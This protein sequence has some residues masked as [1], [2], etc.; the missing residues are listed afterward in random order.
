MKKKKELKLFLP[1]IFLLFLSCTLKKQT[2]E[3]KNGDIIFQISKSNQS[4]AIQIATNSKYSHVGIIFKK[5]GKYYVYEAIRR[6]TYTPLSEWIKRGENG[7]YVV[8]RLKNAKQILTPQTLRKMKKEGKKFFGKPYDLYFEWS[9]DK[10]YCSELVWKIYK[11]SAGV[12]IG[13]LRKLKDFNLSNK[14][15]R[16]KLTER[17]GAKIPL[18][19]PV[20]SPA[21]LFNSPK[22]IT[23]YK[24]D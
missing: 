3:L 17:F 19:E 9:D 23:V 10:L 13:E 22:L 1:L 5:N 24:R 2:P 16:K 18:N 7:E 14:Y 21:D 20:I 8:K 12:E 6:V 15:V 11:R 4:K